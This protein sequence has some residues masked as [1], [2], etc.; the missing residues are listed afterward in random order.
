MRK[1]ASIQKI[2]EIKPI[3]G[4]DMIEAL[5][6]LDWW[7]VGKKGEF[8][9]GDLVCYLEVD[10]F[11]PTELAPFLTKPNQFPKE[12]NGVKGE[13][14]RSIKL[15]G[16][17]SQGLILPL[18]SIPHFT[19]I[20]LDD[21]EGTDVTELLGIQKWEAPIPANLAG[22]SRGNFPTHLIRKTD[23]ERI[24]SYWKYVSARPTDTYE[25][26]MKL[27]GSSCTIF[28]YEDE[29]R[30]CSRNL[31]LKITDE[32]TDNTF[33]RMAL[34]YGHLIPDN[35]VL[36][37]EVMGPGVQNNKEN[38]KEHEFFV[39][40]IFCI[41]TQK[42]F[43][44][45]NR[46]SF[47]E[48]L[49]ILHVPVLDENAPMPESVAAALEDADGPSMNAKLREGIVYKSNSDPSFSFKAISNKWLLKTGE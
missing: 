49:G 28:R 45:V 14:L 40:D 5:R 42:Y 8:A 10:S 29:L 6:V 48:N 37:G 33:V 38:L 30:V 46:R 2:V 36:Q 31:E 25:K 1:L 47:C 27:D 17:L 13:R 21:Y 18:S 41:K 44:P 22:V 43:F 12:Y 9:V 19:A 20:S 15:R 39:F 11:V 7:V 35:L 4:A 34:K 32:N 3:E 16:Q 24:Q 23:Q 26:T